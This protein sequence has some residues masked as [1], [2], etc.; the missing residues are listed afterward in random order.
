MAYTPAADR[1]DQMQ[2]RRCGSSGLKLPA[3]SLG[4]WHNFGGD[5]EDDVPRAIHAL[6]EGHVDHLFPFIAAIAVFIALANAANTIKP[7]HHEIT[8]KPAKVLD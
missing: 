6:A 5:R 7:Q 2:Y 3:I 1:Y 8:A 4:L